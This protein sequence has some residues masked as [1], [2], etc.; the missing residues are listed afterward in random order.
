MNRSLYEI[1]EDIYKCFDGETGEILDIEALEALQLERD[2]KLESIALF[3]KNLTSEAAAIKEEEKALAERRKA[4]EAKAESLTEYLAQALDGSPFETAKCSV[5]FRKSAA[6]EI[7]DGE[8]VLKFLE[9][10]GYDLCINYQPA[11]I[12]LK[13]VGD[14][15][16]SGVAVPC[17]DIVERKNIN[18][19]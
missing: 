5:K 6:V 4:K 17:A 10:N 3:I 16:K 19:K 8:K 2:E 13:E 7:A 18:I 1:N 12:R 11:K 15:I 9:D 14:L